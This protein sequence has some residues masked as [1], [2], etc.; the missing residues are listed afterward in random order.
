VLALGV[1]C[2][3]SVEVEADGLDEQLAIRA[4]C[5]LVNSNFLVTIF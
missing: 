4:L 2:G 1:Y 3:H 5:D